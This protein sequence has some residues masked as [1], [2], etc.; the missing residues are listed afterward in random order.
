LGR[1]KKKY[2]YE[3]IEEIIQVVSDRMACS[4]GLDR[5]VEKVMDCLNSGFND[6]AVS[7]VGIYGVPGI[8]KST[9]ANRVSR[10]G[11]SIEF[12][13]C[14]FLDKVSEYA[15]E[16]GLVL[17]KQF[18]L[19][20]I[21][22]H[23]N[24]TMLDQKKIFLILEDI[25]DP[26]VLN[27]ILELTTLFGYG[28]RVVI[29]TQ[30][31]YLLHNC[32]IKRI[33]EVERLDNNEARQFLCLKV[34]NSVKFD[35]SYYSILERAAAYASGHP[36]ILEAIG[37]H[38]SGKGVEECEKALDQYEMIQNHEIQEI[39]QVSYNALGEF[40][41]KM[42][43]HIEI[44]HKERDLSQVEKNLFTIYG[45]CP[46]KDI[47]VLI[48]KGFLKINERRLVT[49]HCLTLAMVRYNASLENPCKRSRL[50]TN[51]LEENMEY[52]SKFSRLS[53]DTLEENIKVVKIAI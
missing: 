24:I 36:F 1:D 9:L 38:L 52:S 33:Y 32:G 29:T 13:K 28:S 14:C 49:L 20:E 11:G 16:H 31:K 3:Y 18:L 42:L 53:K 37:S 27:V 30:D 21:S 34:R 5:R 6:N 17:L 46:K 45:N 41:Q 43:S 19:F 4:V 25:H 35:L 10:F 51:N 8:G 50:S 47:R 23:D 7:V 12:G 2:Q 39:L 22:G 40:H 44:H 26:K 48:D 15:S